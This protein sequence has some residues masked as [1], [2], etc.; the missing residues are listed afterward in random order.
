M[1]ANN[2]WVYTLSLPLCAIAAIILNIRKPEY[3]VL[4]HT[5]GGA[6]VK[7]DALVRGVIFVLIAYITFWAAIRNGVADT[8][9]YINN[10]KSL[11]TDINLK[12]L[13][14]DSEQNGVKS[15][16]FT[17]YQIILKRLGFNW[18]FFLASVA[19]ISGFCIYK[20]ISK[21]SD[22]VALS[23]YLF[24]TGLYY[25]WFFNGMRQFLVAAI[26]F[27]NLKLIVEKKLWKLLLLV[28]LLYFIHK[29][30]WIII[31]IYFIANMKNWSY[32]IYACILATMAVVILFPNQFTALL[33][34]SFSEYNVA[35]EFAKDD[36]VNV[37]RFLVSMVTPILAFIYKDKIAEYE[38]PYVN[39][40]VNMS[41][42]TGGLYAVG[43]VTSGIYMGRLP[44][45]TDLFGLI[46]LPFI[47]K[48][49]LPNQSKGTVFAAC[50]ILYF[51]Y[52][53][54]QTNNNTYYTTNWF[55]SMD[56]GGAQL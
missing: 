24:I 10:Y 20:G 2:A 47:L 22:D 34:D 55:P 50:L 52:F 33:D 41:L 17:L 19:A 7:R 6:K 42:I 31:P 14:L 53:Y 1:F 32:G 21:Y 27:A 26:L 29:T 15:P 8:A 56:M 3:S 44:I 9:A 48:R 11:S 37:L 13:F 35:E 30:V 23:Y 45:Y 16:L 28:L 38:N 12:Q 4:E 51:V 40:M 49:V 36:G 5:I 54:L 25:T 46:L 43:V 39:V 18:Q